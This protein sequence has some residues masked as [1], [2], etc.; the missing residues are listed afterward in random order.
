MKNKK[1]IADEN[2][3]KKSIVFPIIL[4]ILVIGGG[5]YGYKEYQH[6]QHHG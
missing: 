4:G 2:T 5:I 3:K 6:G 1:N